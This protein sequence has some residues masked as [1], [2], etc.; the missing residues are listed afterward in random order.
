MLIDFLFISRLLDNLSGS[1]EDKEEVDEPE[2]TFRVED[3]L[4]L[5]IE[6]RREKR[7]AEKVLSQLQAN[8]DELQRKYAE[9]E[10]KIDKL[11]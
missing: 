5:A 2:E 7:E 8:Y 6:E 11:R 1:E 4:A 10:N 9:A 3:V